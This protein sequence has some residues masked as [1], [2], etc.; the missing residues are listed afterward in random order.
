MS[1]FLNNL[2]YD[3]GLRLLSGSADLLFISSAS[4]GLWA[5]LISGSTGSAII[6]AGS[7]GP[8]DGGSGRMVVIPASSGSI[9]AGTTTGCWIL[10][11][12]STCSVLASG[13]MSGSQSTTIG[14]A[15]TLTQ[16]SVRIPAPA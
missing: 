2:V 15:W 1:G 13:S 12:N 5:D 6:T 7:A 16:F 11:N 14:N 9:W 8:G 3:Y 4:A 10:V